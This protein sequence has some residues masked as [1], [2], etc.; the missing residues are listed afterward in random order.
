MTDQQQ[1]PR[2]VDELPPDFFAK[3]FEKVEEHRA[4]LEA[5]EKKA[6]KRKK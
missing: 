4:K 6:S 1:L 2:T 5:E 3:V